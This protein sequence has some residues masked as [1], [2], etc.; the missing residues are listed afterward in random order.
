MRHESEKKKKKGA[1]PYR[2]AH[3]RRKVNGTFTSHLFPRRSACNYY[4]A[5][6]V[7][8]AQSSSSTRRRRR[9]ERKSSQVNKRALSTLLFSWFCVGLGCHRFGRF[10]CHVERP[11][12]PWMPNDDCRD[13]CTSAHRRKSLLFF[14]LSFPPSSC[15][16]FFVFFPIHRVNTRTSESKREIDEKWNKQE[17]KRTP[18]IRGSQQGERWSH[19]EDEGCTLHR[20][21]MM[22]MSA[23]PLGTK[24]EKLLFLISFSL[25]G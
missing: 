20:L 2:A 4:S 15:F 17:K 19:G 14:I 1:H 12:R 22:M 3:W 7:V 10:S 25:T 13:M 5:A 11:S 18:H 16:Y 9:K 24:P 21:M 8:R 23:G 6:V